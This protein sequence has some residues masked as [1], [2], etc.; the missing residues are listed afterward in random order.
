M[1]IE[2]IAENI[3]SEAKRKSKE[4]E[5]DAAEQKSKILG[6]AKEQANIILEQA[7][8]DA[9]AKAEGMLNEHRAEL[10]VEKHNEMLL[11]QSFA[12]EKEVIIARKLFIKRISGRFGEI[13]KRAAKAMEASSGGFAI[14]AGKEYAK[15]IKS[16]GYD[17]DIGTGIVVKSRDG[18]ATID[19]SPGILFDE[20]A[21]LAKSKISISLFRKAAE[22]R[23][24]KEASNKSAKPKAKKGTKRK[25]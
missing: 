17:V 12:V 10:E 19:L 1:P 9:Q 7:K 21:D 4:I 23:A 2:E 6:E 3:I 15:L 20:N 25:R 13:V 16:V 14:N 8:K 24:K 11:A 22:A 5:A 18:K